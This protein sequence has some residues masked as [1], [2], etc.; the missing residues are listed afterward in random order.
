MSR[1]HLKCFEGD[2]PF[3][4]DIQSNIISPGNERTRDGRQSS[5]FYLDSTSQ[6]SSNEQFPAPPNLSAVFDDQEVRSPGQIPQL[7]TRPHMQHSRPRPSETRE[8][9]HN[10]FLQC[11]RL[12]FLEKFPQ[13]SNRRLPLL[14]TVCLSVL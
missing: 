8:L 2:K 12:R 5:L 7:P 6:K 3:N 13:Q 4:P 9:L 1:S 10:L 14:K 11:L